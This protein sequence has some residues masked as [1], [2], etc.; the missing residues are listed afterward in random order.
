L[1]KRVLIIHAWESSPQEHWY[2]EEKK[3]LEEMG[4]EVFLPELPGGR[5]PKL[6]EWLEIIKEFKPD[7]N[8]ILIGHSLGPAAILRYLEKSGQKVETIISIAGFAKSLGFKET[9]NFV[10]EP[11][12]WETIRKNANKIISIAQKNDPYVPIDVSKEIADR[13][14]GEFMLVDGDNHF[15]KMDLDLINRYL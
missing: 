7:E 11:F 13:T 5:W 12:D 9:D 8:T 10:E 2:E 6:V 4:Y 15:D 1:K 3:I 14:G